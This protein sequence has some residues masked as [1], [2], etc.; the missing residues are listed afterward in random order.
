MEQ[1]IGCRLE[2]ALD[3]G[4]NL[5]RQPASQ[6]HHPIVID[7]HRHRAMQM[8]S[9]GLLRRLDAIHSPPGADDALDLSRRAGECDLD[10]SCLV[11]RYRDPRERPDFGIRHFAALHRGAD[12]RQRRQR[13]G[14]TDLF[15]GRTQI[16]ARPPVQPMRAREEAV[17]PAGARTSSS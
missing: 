16:D 3:N 13:A 8:T 9:F 11:A 7:M 1:A 15:A 2:G 12:V 17:V 10:Q 5:G 14:N 6:D 4:T